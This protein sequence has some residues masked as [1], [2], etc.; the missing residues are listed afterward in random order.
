MVITDRD[1]SY[2]ACGIV[3]GRTWDFTKSIYS[4]KEL[5]SY[6]KEDLIN[7]ILKGLENNNLD[8]GFGFESLIACKIKITKTIKLKFSKSS[9]PEDNNLIFINKSSEYVILGNND[10]GTHEI[11]NNLNV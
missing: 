1:V 2:K 10:N 9:Y 7:L 5:K 3:A 11:L 4:T 8:N 6:S